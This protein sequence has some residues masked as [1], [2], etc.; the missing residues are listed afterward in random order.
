MNDTQTSEVAAVDSAV[1]Q[2][3]RFAFSFD[4]NFWVGPCVFFVYR[5]LVLPAGT[6]LFLLH[7]PASYRIAIN[8]GPSLA[9]LLLMF[10]WHRRF[11]A[12][13]IS[14]VGDFRRRDFLIGA[15]AISLLYVAT[16]GI[17]VA[18]H[19]PREPLMAGLFQ[20]LTPLGVCVLIISLVALP[21]IVEE[22]AFRHFLM[23]P[24]PF[25]KSTAWSSVA[26][27]T[28]AVWF[29]VVHPYIYL[30]S[31]VT[32]FIMG[33]ILG[34]ARVRSHGMLLPMCLHAYSICFALLADWIRSS[35][36]L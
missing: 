29:T 25:R 26:V 31:D 20:S 12:D 16:N 36:G 6:L 5:W 24:F 22:L 17:A 18:I 14:F 1:I 35:H 11:F 23:A 33:V 2:R 13:S 3:R 10:F 19:Q 15:V 7:P 34:V 4:R 21:P 27:I 8:Y 9:F 30:T 32:I 28:T